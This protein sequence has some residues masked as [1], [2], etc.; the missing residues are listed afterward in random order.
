[1]KLTYKII[2]DIVT[3]NIEGLSNLE[4]WEPNLHLLY[5]LIN[6]YLQVKD[7][8]C[9][10]LTIPLSTLLKFESYELSRLGFPPSNPYN[11]FFEVDSTIVEKEFTPRIHF[12]DKF[13]RDVYYEELIFSEGHLVPFITINSTQYTIREPEYSLLNSLFLLKDSSSQ[14]RNERLQLFMKIQDLAS[15]EVKTSNPRLFQIKIASCH[16]LGLDLMPTSEFTIVPEL[17]LDDEG[18]ETQLNEIDSTNFKKSFLSKNT[19]PSKYDLSRNEIILFST[20]VK[21]LLNEIKSINKESRAKRKAF[22]YNPE[23][24]VKEK[25]ELLYSNPL[26]AQ[27]IFND[28][29]VVSETYASKRIS[30]IGVFE[31][32]SGSF[33]QKDKHRWIPEDVVGVQIDDSIFEI[34]VGDIT[35]LSNDIQGAIKGNISSVVYENQ[36][37]PASPA[38]IEALGGLVKLD[39]QGT[40][41][42]SVRNP[43]KDKDTKLVPIIINNV[44]GSTFQINPRPKLNHDFYLSKD[45]LLQPKNQEQEEGIEWLCKNYSEGRSGVI[46]ADDMG[47][48]KTFQTL[49]F[50]KW[51]QEISTDNKK[52]IL[53]VGPTALLKNWEAEQKKFLKHGLGNYINTNGNDYNRFKSQPINYVVRDLSSYDFILATYDFIRIN[54][55]VFR[56][57]PFSIIVFDEVQKLK[58]PNTLNTH[59]AKALSFEFSIAISGTPVENHLGDLWTI[60]DLVAPMR[61]GTLKNYVQRYHKD[62]LIEELEN[63][64]FHET[65]PPF[66]LRRLK[67]NVLKGL[68]EKNI[69]HLKVPMSHSQQNSYEDAIERCKSSSTEKKKGPQ[70]LLELKVLSLHATPL[71]V[72]DEEF[73]KENAKIQA[74][75]NILDEVKAKNEKVIIFVERKEL[76]TRIL[77]LLSNL[78]S[79]SPIGT[80]INGEV[81]GEVRQNFVDNFYTRSLGFDVMLISPRAGGVGLTITCANNVIHLERWWNPAVENQATDRVYRIGQEKNVNVYIPMTYHPKYPNDSFDIILDDLLRSKSQLSESL[82]NVTEFTEQDATAF[83]TRATG[84]DARDYYFRTN[85]DL[86]ND[87]EWQTLRKEI[88]RTYPN[89]CF[90]CD[91]VEKLQVDH[92][93]PRSKYP[94]LTYDF[95]NLQILCERCN[96]SKSS[97]D[98]PAWDYRHRF[99]ASIILKEC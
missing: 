20:P 46:L 67:K 53:I 37:I 58:N 25:L 78:Y 8:S 72:S 76:Q 17:Y 55:I 86:L 19:V 74:M 42:T 93:K 10:G 75:I 26:E 56:Q 83:F 91:S 27:D 82:L 31:P 92:V 38:A 95:S 71:D 79:I 87:P 35:Q 30:H 70:T 44:D 51:Y 24:F 11:L 7:K 12:R 47:L 90:K 3:F 5:P 89:Q 80:L 4:K 23:K 54:E 96:R 66:V 49:A 52:P 32:I 1:M 81:P 88:F 16:K 15:P 14:S 48:G 60:S 13:N 68:P 69:I 41:E 57:I 63:K 6:Y 64:L 50:L 73:I 94:E 9:P 98:D 45:L 33:I 18:K 62:G 61:L 59:M 29:F 40:P 39:N 43:T 84:V 28:I 85:D 97:S 2:K 21:T 34:K 22:F 65:P 36:D 99:S 77:E